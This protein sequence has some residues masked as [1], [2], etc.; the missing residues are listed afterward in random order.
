MVITD[1]GHS[2]LDIWSKILNQ[3]INTEDMILI[4]CYKEVMIQ[5]KANP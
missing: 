2:G 3:A 5:T 4:T 1:E